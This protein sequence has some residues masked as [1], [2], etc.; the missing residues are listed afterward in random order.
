M[1]KHYDNDRYEDFEDEY[2]T[3]DTDETSKDFYRV[4]KMSKGSQRLSEEERKQ[5]KKARKAIRG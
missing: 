5:I 2:R 1:S 3:Q 4:R